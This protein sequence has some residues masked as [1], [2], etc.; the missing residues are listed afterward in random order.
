M[1]LQDTHFEN[2]TLIKLIHAFPIVVTVMTLSLIGIFVLSM[3]NAKW[4]TGVIF[5]V[6]AVVELLVLSILHS[7]V[8]YAK[9][10]LT[11]NRNVLQLAEWLA[12]DPRNDNKPGVMDLRNRLNSQLSANYDQYYVKA[13]PDYVGDSDDEYG[14]QLVDLLTEYDQLTGEKYAYL[15]LVFAR[16]MY[17]QPKKTPMLDGFYHEAGRQ[18][19]Q[20]IPLDGMSVC[21]N[22]STMLLREIDGD[23]VNVRLR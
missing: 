11:A 16:V 12:T 4:W 9:A 1:T 22:G 6:T 21:W 18:L 2:R 14:R 8:E 19:S 15:C 7:A 20:G 13:P 23:G 3:Q 10:S 5:G 17:E